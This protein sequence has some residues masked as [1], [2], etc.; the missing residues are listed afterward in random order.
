MVNLELGLNNV[1]VTLSERVE[2]AAPIYLVKITSQNNPTDSKIALLTDISVAS[3]RVN[4]L[5][6]EVVTTSEDLA[7]GKI[8]LEGG[9]YTY[10][11]YESAD[12]IL[13]VTGKHLLETGMMRY[14]TPPSMNTYNTNT[15]GEY[16]YQG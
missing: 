6:L 5:L 1:Y 9:D 7:N 14:S 2:L 10:E 15:N 3:E 16:T 8:L 13:D 12:A 4:N 11:F